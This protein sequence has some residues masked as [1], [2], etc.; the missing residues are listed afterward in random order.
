MAG[1]RKCVGVWIDHR[2]ALVASLTNAEPHIM[3]IDSHFEGY[4]RPQGGSR[5]P[6][7]Y[8]HNS[9][10][11]E[12]KFQERRRQQLKFFYRNVIKEIEDADEILIMGGGEAKKELE[13]EIYN[14]KNLSQKIVGVITADEMTEG[15]IIADMKKFYRIPVKRHM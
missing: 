12:K 15:Q 8:G 11:D 4:F 13:R 3:H 5:V 9:I 10:C 1:K 2:K 14:H 7:P 6:T